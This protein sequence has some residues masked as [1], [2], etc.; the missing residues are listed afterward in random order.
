M[1]DDLIVM[2]TQQVTTSELPQEGVMARVRH[3]IETKT[4]NFLTSR[5][6]FHQS[7]CDAL[8]VVMSNRGP[9]I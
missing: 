3:K 4:L 5:G 6:D 7:E 9:N 8:G 1:N 2:I